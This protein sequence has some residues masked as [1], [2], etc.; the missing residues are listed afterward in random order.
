MRQKRETSRFH[1]ANQIVLARKT[2]AVQG[3]GFGE[4]LEV[5]NGIVK[6]SKGKGEIFIARG[7]N[8]TLEG[9]I[10][11]ISDIIAYINH[12]LDDALRAGVLKRSAIPSYIFEV[13]ETHSKRIDTMV[14]DVIS[15]SLLS[16]LQEITMSKELQK[17][18]YALRDFLYENVY[19]SD[20]SKREFK[21]ARKILLDLY[22]YYMEH[23]DEI[24]KE[25]SQDMS[26]KKERM[27]CDFIAGM[28]DRFALA[29]YEQ[30]FLPQPWIVL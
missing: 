27:V 8:E 26:G 17:I 22:D 29:M 9:Q 20:S 24:S 30:N 28:T 4:V 18:T 14:K 10:V 7:K 15:C 25:F 13:G 12:D 19:E 16:D 11:E 23:T 21:K 6:H 3:H 5:R 1:G 2:I